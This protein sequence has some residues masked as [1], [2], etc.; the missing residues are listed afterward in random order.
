MKKIKTGS[1]TK[2][3]LNPYQSTIPSSA[4]NPMDMLQPFMP[5]E[6]GTRGVFGRG[7]MGKAIDW[8]E[9]TDRIVDRVSRF[10]L[11]E[12]PAWREV[13]DPSHPSRIFDVS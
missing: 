1:T 2:G 5:T 7:T 13:D 10:P 12:D 4:S 9:E 11:T 3:D 8:A 6:T